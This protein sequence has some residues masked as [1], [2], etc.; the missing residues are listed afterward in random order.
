[1][2]AAADAV[3]AAEYSRN[4]DIERKISQSSRSSL[5]EKI[6]DDAELQTAK[7]EAEVASAQSRSHEWYLKLRPLILV[8]LALTILGWWISATVLKTT[9]HRWCIRIYLKFVYMS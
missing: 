9:R 3:L 4:Y 7:D 5:K 1:M 8:A 6:K 2:E